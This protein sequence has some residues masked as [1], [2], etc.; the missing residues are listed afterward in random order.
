MLIDAETHNTNLIL[1]LKAIFSEISIG[2]SLGFKGGTAARIFYGLDRYSVDLDF[3]LLSRSAEALIFQKI[4]DLLPEIGVVKE[5]AIKKYT[6]FF[7]VSYAKEIRNIKIEISRRPSEASY[8]VLNLLGFPVKV[9]TREDMFANKLMALLERKQLAHRDM[10]D[11]NFFC[12]NKW[13]LN[14]SLL[15]KKTGMRVETYLKKTIKW[16]SNY[17]DKNIL[18]GLGELLTEKQKAWTKAHLKKDLLFHLRLLLDTVKRSKN[19]G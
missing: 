10:Y 14:G 16:L 1:I 17:D 11:L 13:P 9:I 6:I 18:Y 5:K 3:D 15:E 4:G 2:P 8:R 19:L 12:K 7:L